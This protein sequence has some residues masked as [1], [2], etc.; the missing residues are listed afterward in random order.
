MGFLGLDSWCHC[1]QP[2]AAA[3]PPASQEPEQGWGDAVGAR[4]RRGRRAGN[5]ASAPCCSLLSHSPPTPAPT[6]LTPDTPEIRP[7]TF[8]F[9]LPPTCSLFAVASLPVQPPTS[10]S[11]HCARVCAHRGGQ[12]TWASAPFMP[13]HPLFPAP[14][15]VSSPGFLGPDLLQ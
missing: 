5:Q 14:L 1:P 6:P 8:S 15:V 12:G 13:F 3:L 11:G 9:L 7:V 4:G 10:G 2:G